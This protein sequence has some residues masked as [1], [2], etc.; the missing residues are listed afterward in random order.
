MIWTVNQSLSKEVKSNRK[1]FS[2]KGAT[3]PW[4]P[5]IIDEET[6]TELTTFE[7]GETDFWGQQ[8]RKRR[9]YLTALYLKAM[10]VLGHPHYHPKDL[11]LQFRR[12]LSD[13]LCLDRQLSKIQKLDRSE[14]SRIVESV[15]TFLGISVPT[16]D[17]LNTLK[18]WLETDI[19]HKESD[20]QMVTNA[21]IHNLIDKKIELPTEKHL[22]VLVEKAINQANQ[23]FVDRVNDHLSIDDKKRLE[24]LTK[25]SVLEKF[26]T[27]APKAS[28]NNMAK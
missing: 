7:S 8:G 20:I 15:R 6:L 26:K 22:Q 23:N 3:Y 2:K 12:E 17:D 5:A 19:A 18:L 14:K 21:A 4:L 1:G 10:S 13:R 11:P 25:G 24:L 27:P 9:Q 16:S 28:S